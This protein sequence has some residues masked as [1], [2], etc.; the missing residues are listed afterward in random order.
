MSELDER[1]LTIHYLYLTTS[2][3]SYPLVASCKEDLTEHLKQCHLAR[4]AHRQVSS[5]L[6]LCAATAG[7]CHR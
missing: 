7:I 3:H 1:E 2:K 5:L 6:S 4:Y